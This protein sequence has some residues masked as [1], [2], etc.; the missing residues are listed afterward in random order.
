MESNNVSEL[1]VSEMLRKAVADSKSVATELHAEAQRLSERVALEPDELQLKTA[2]QAEQRA[3]NQMKALV[4]DVDLYALMKLTLRSYEVFMA[5]DTKQVIPLT[6]E[7]IQV[8]ESHAA[9]LNRII[10][11]AFRVCHDKKAYCRF[12]NGACYYS[13]EQLTK[14]PALLSMCKYRGKAI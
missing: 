14:Q 4:V 6:P 7:E 13:D 9:T 8:I 11:N 12:R 1:E 3:S 10:K 2:K 5:R